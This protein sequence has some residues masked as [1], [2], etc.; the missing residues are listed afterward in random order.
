M[1]GTT[2]NN[3]PLATSLG[4]AELIWI[5]Q[6]TGNPI[7]PWVGIACT[8]QQIANLIGGVYTFSTLPATPHDGNRAY[9]TDS[10]AAAIGNFGASVSGGGTNH[11]PIY[12]D[13]GSSLWRIG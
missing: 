1:A 11:V 4:G 2:L 10:T 3:L 5:Y 12:Y 6:P 13:G 7:S 8:T 9:I